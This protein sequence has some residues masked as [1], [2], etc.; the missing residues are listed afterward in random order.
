LLV[1]FCSKKLLLETNVFLGKWEK[2]T[3]ER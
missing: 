3:G 2:G 1:L